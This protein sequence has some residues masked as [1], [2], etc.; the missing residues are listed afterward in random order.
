MKHIFLIVL[1]LPGLFLIPLLLPSPASG[2]TDV[3][4]TGYNN[5]LDKI[6]NGNLSILIP[7]QNVITFNST[8]TLAPIQAIVYKNGVISNSNLTPV[9]LTNDDWMV[10]PAYPKGVTVTRP[11]KDRSGTIT[12][13][14]SAHA[15]T[16]RYSYSFTKPAYI[17][18]NNKYSNNPAGPA[19]YDVYI[20]LKKGAKSAQILVDTDY[21]IY[22]EVPINGGLKLTKARYRGHSSSSIENGYE[23]VN[24][25]KVAYRPEHERAPLDAQIDIS[26]YADRSFES[27][28]LWPTPG[29][30]RNTGFY[31]MLYN[32]AADS[33]A[34]VLGYYGGRASLILGGN[35][36]G[37]RLVLK[38]KQPY[39]KVWVHRRSDD[40]SFFGRKRFE[41]G[42]WVST[43]A[44]VLTPTVYQPIVKDYNKYAGLADRVDRYYNTPLQ[45]VTGFDDGAFYTDSAKMQAMIAE[46]KNPLSTFYQKLGYIDPYFKQDIAVAWKEPFVA[47]RLIQ[48]IINYGEYVRDAMKNKDGIA[49]MTN[50]MRL[51]F[52]EGSLAMK[53]RAMQVAC[54]LADHTLTI[55]RNRRDSLLRCVSMFARIAHDQD[56]GPNETPASVAGIGFGTANMPIQHKGSQDFF[57]L[58]F[59]GDKEF[60]AKA[61]SLFS[62]TVNSIDRLIKEGGE[63]VATTHYLE[64]EN[65]NL[66]YTVL[67][68]IT[69]GA[70]N[71]AKV[72]EIKF[73]KYADFMQS[74]MTPPVPA[75]GN[76]RKIV[77]IDD[78]MMEMN[79]QVALLAQI[80]RQFDTS[81][82]NRL[83]ALYQNGGP[84]SGPDFGYIPLAIDLIT[85]HNESLATTMGSYAGYFSGARSG[86]NTPNES[87]YRLFTGDSW[88]DHRNPNTRNVAE[89]WSLQAPVSQWWSSI[90]YPHVEHFGMRNIVVPFSQYPEWNKTTEIKATKNGGQVIYDASSLLEYAKLGT[91][92]ISRGKATNARGL[93]WER[94]MLQIAV[95]EEKPIVLIKDSLNNG[96]DNIFNMTYFSEGAV[97]TP[98]GNV[99]PDDAFWDADNT[100]NQNN[101]MATPT[102]DLKAGMGHF[103]FTGQGFPTA[104]HPSGGINW[105]VLSILPGGGQFVLSQ[106]TNNWQNEAE[107]GEWVRAMSA[108]GYRAYRERQQILR[109]KAKGNIV[110]LLLP[111]TKGQSSPYAG[112][113][114]VG[115]KITLP[116]GQGKTMIVSEHGYYYSSPTK[117]VVTSFGVQGF[118]EGAY[119]I[120]GGIAEVEITADTVKIRVH[121]NSGTRKIILPFNTKLVNNPLNA[122]LVKGTNT[123]EIIIPYTNTR[124]NVLSYEQ[125]YSEIILTRSLTS[126]T[127]KPAAINHN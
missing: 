80:V 125:G 19:F 1:L 55:P 90:Y 124:L 47:N 18:G 57:T 65:S 106:W 118:S 28:F 23:I 123:S 112:A 7:K 105:D 95:E 38:N 83:Y 51:R 8:T 44:D 66:F 122:S 50:G 101:P 29:G 56:F 14:Q 4:I 53:K 79:G 87:T 91:T 54:I 34:N 33:T 63:G 35:A 48:D 42:I 16:I 61:A 77:P 45:Q 102:Y 24:G 76:R 30:M 3:S 26:S 70:G 46:V 10:Q 62:E 73:R 60:S 99:T 52:F 78:A 72:R 114:Y 117:A 119:G 20:T 67:H 5:K 37:V 89:V 98:T 11:T 71:P 40:N 75:M 111:Y 36:E 59:A 97:N 21:D 49:E 12:F 69:S 25:S 17:Y 27:L 58:I 126:Q 120:R 74:L 81:L 93:F 88:Y 96:A 92:V 110:T 2:Q 85:P 31:W 121:G 100:R 68:L 104:Y 41:F 113:V 39:L 103:Y 94:K 109:I 13:E 9:Y 32:E 43:K 86:L 108:L 127:A 115:G 6:S 15:R 107:K 64:A 116:F 22:F 82:S 84:K